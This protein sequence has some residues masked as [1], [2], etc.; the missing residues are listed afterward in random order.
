M[1]ACPCTKNGLK[2]FE[3]HFLRKKLCASMKKITIFI[4]LI[5]SEVNIDSPAKGREVRMLRW[6]FFIIF[7][8]I[9]KY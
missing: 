7:F 3:A 9:L 2:M 1:P 4:I 5:I 8:S 6:C